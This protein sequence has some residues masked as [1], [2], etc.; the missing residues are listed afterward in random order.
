MIY[1]LYD[2]FRATQREFEAEM[3]HVSEYN[4]SEFY[5]GFRA[6]HAFQKELMPEKSAAI[7]SAYSTR[8]FR[9]HTMQARS[10]IP[11]AIWAKVFLVICT[12]VYFYMVSCIIMF[13]D[14]IP[15]SIQISL[16]ETFIA[17]FVLD[18]IVEFVT[19]YCIHI[20]IPSVISNDLHESKQYVISR[21]KS[22][23]VKE[24]I[25]ESYDSFNL[26]R[27]LSVAYLFTELYTELILESRIIRE[28]EFSPRNIAI[29]DAEEN[30]SFTLS[31]IALFCKLSQLVQDLIL[32][33]STSSVVGVV[34]VFIAFMYHFSP[35]FAMWIG[36]AI[37]AVV[38]CFLLF[39]SFSCKIEP[40][41][42]PLEELVNCNDQHL[43]IG[44][45]NSD[46]L[47]NLRCVCLK[48]V[49]FLEIS[50]FIY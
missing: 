25:L 34:L 9:I 33:L 16:C 40:D 47:V 39:N 6:L 5:R 8:M 23:D 43:N 17:W 27:F 1:R 37:G 48:S 26:S 21:L 44:I 19:V 30:H 42:F 35:F 4:S 10:H 3:N 13:G 2:K 50:S 46:S 11:T 12:G 7:L 45:Y 49:Y 41:E 20:A 15:D 22:I 36:G 14:R 32:R 24:Q 38:V 28:K 29:Y 18:F 31:V